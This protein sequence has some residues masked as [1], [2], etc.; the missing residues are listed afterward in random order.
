MK[1]KR[2]KVT[3]KE[4]QFPKAI[5]ESIEKDQV[6]ITDVIYS[7]RGDLD[8]DGEY[9]DTYSIL[10]QK[11][12]YVF[13]DLSRNAAKRTHFYKGVLEI[14]QEQSCE[15]EKK[16]YLLED[17]DFLFVIT[18][19]G[20]NQLVLQKKDQSRE[21]LTSFTNCCQNGMHELTRVVSQMKDGNKV[22]IPEEREIFCPKCGRMYPDE[23]R[24]LCP[25]CM[26]KK[27][28]LMRIMSYFKPYRVK[29]VILMMAV[30]CSSLINLV[31]PYLNGTVLYDKILNQ[32]SGFIKNY[33]I[34]RNDFFVALFI[35]T[36]TMLATKTCMLLID[37][38]RR[39]LTV[40][41]VVNV[42]RD[43]KQDVFKTMSRQSIRFYK[44]KQTG[45]LM[46]RVLSDAEHVVDFF[47][48]GAPNVIVNIVMIIVTLIVMF[49]MN[50]W[51]T[52]TAICLFPFMWM[53]NVYLRPRIFVAHGKRHRAEKSVNNAL[54]D[55][56]VGARVVKCFGQ[57]EKSIQ[58]FVHVNHNLRDREIEIT[59]RRNYFHFA[60]GF[61][62]SI[63]TVSTWFLGTYFIM[64]GKNMNLGLLMTFAGYIG[65]ISGPI[66][67]FANVSN[68]WA[69][70][71]NS[72]QRMFEIMDAIPDVENPAEPI[73]L[74]E[75]KG[76]IEIRNMT[77]GYDKNHP[78]LRNVNL[79]IPAGTMYG[80]VGRSGAGKT[81]L[82][83]LISRMYDVNEGEIL[84]DGVNVKKLGFEELRRN[85][86][87]VSQD[88]YIFSGTV[89]DNIRYAKEEADL[90]DVMRAAKLAGAHE[91]I[92]R[93][94]DGYDTMI[95]SSKRALSGGE[96]QRI[97][98]AR[99]ILSD[100]KIL[101]L[102]EAT[103]SVDTET[104]RVI[105]KSLSYLV[106]G[107]TT[108]SIAHRLS[109]LYDADYLVVID[110][111]TITERGTHEELKAQKGTYYKLLKLQT[112]ALQR[113]DVKEVRPQG[114]GI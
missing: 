36:L 90:K 107:R 99:A 4:C 104:E 51:M 77:F 13:K 26:E 31:W 65:Q 10:T 53:V 3:T 88:T 108:I 83:N 40:K 75:M 2:L 71:M 14:E 70:S 44:N 98:I 92:M 29:L 78:V 30:V 47:L 9:R 66:R 112:E 93:L 105:Q 25:H 33:P 113:D 69:D 37:I 17:T 56:L 79:S 96:R 34:F 111:N 28:I 32:D 72:A 102:D 106:K 61:A 18:G 19:V 11:M 21:I 95:G 60:Y 20:S 6:K 27:S 81:T 16:T 82:V 89:A 97:S 8:A 43:M 110:Q 84:I 39:L 80:I 24:K 68:W 5:L 41:M 87:M 67:F 59:Y 86:A 114:S 103:A 91:F 74:G 46:T 49:R 94:P 38:T 76:R 12:L 58:K 63:L 62:Q 35:L 1:K 100:P 101:I 50:V 15:W 64:K 57:E 85:V 23:Q 54:N 22:D 109:T 7:A 52:I 73:A 55:N 45:G 48:D 42:V